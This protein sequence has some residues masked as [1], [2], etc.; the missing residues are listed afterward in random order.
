MIK[1]VT[2]IFKSVVSE[3]RPDTAGI[4]FSAWLL[5]LR[6]PRLD[7]SFCSIGNMLR[8]EPE[9]PSAD[10]VNPVKS[11]MTSFSFPTSW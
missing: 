4:R 9:F 5:A 7:I 11:V 8:Q 6:D 10:L 3:K 2:I 1:H